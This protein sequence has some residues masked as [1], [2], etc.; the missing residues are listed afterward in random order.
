MQLTPAIYRSA[1]YYFIAFAVVVFAGFWVY[2]VD[3]IGRRG[4]QALVHIH[5]ITMTV[6]CLLLISQA[7]LIRSNR[8]QLHGLIGRSSLFIVPI[9]V[10]LQFAIVP[11]FIERQ[12]GLDISGV[13]DAGAFQLSYILGIC[14]S[15]YCRF[16]PGCM[17]LEVASPTQCVSI[18]LLVV[19]RISDLQPPFLPRSVVEGFL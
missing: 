13:T 6:W 10:A 18:C 15:G 17:G 2:Y 1:P 9:I 4:S 14:D 3:P 7:L 19:N 5:A 12:G 16:H 8:R 11:G